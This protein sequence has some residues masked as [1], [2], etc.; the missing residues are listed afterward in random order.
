MVSDKMAVLSNNALFNGTGNDFRTQLWIFIS[1]FILKFISESEVNSCFVV[2]S[3]SRELLLTERF[4]SCDVKDFNPKVWIG[5]K[6][7]K[8][9]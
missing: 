2:V 8:K 5:K 4:N 1:D 3:A 7:K 6:K 9:M